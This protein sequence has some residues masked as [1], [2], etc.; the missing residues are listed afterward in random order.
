LLPSAA[1]LRL[2]AF[3]TFVAVVLSAASARV[4]YA[5]VKEAA[6]SAGHEIA[7]LSDATRGAEI[8]WFNGV[9]FH[10][11]SVVVDAT[12][13]DVLD[14]V[15]AHCE[16]APNLLGRAL[17]AIPEKEAAKKLGEAPSR[18][19]RH[20]VFR[21]NARDGSRGMIICFV[22]DRPYS[23]TDVERRLEAF[24][25]SHD[26][27][28]FGRL[29]YAYVEKL[30]SGKTHVLSMWTDSGL[31][32]KAMF[33]GEGDAAGSDSVVLPRPLHSRR[34]LAANAEALPY[35]VRL[36]DSTDSAEAVRAF[37]DSWMRAHG[38]DKVE[39]KGEPGASYIRPDGFQAFVAVGS[40][41]GKTGVSL[42]EAGRA[43]GTS[44]AVVQVTE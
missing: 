40:R 30:R 37:Y 43:D 42:L 12:P 31:D 32:V 5:D 9:R 23:F 25:E 1:V 38:F 36:Y 6:L 27:T 28:V 20:G 44:N 29:R 11:G 4:I 41:H 13:V 15:E 33:P 8:V 2:S 35:A 26:V 24:N 14:R 39:A 10:H 17:L 3:L 21:E 34:T 16:E 7:G 18:A 22:D 19:F